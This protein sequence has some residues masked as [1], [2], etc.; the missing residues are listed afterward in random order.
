MRQTIFILLLLACLALAFAGRIKSESEE[1]EDWEGDATIDDPNDLTIKHHDDGNWSFGYRT[2]NN[3]EVHEESENTDIVKG[4]Y[5]YVDPDG[6][7]VK[8]T[9]I[10]GAGIGFVPYS[11]VIDD[12]IMKS[13]E[14]NLK[15]PPQNFDSSEEGA[16]R[17]PVRDFSFPT[18]SPK[19]R[20]VSNVVENLDKGFETEQKVKATTVRN[21][22]RMRKVQSNLAEAVNDSEKEIVENV[23]TPQAVDNNENVKVNVKTVE[24]EKLK[25]KLIEESKTVDDEVKVA[26]DDLK[27]EES[28]SDS[29]AKNLD[30]V[31]KVKDAV[32]K[33]VNRGRKTASKVLAEAKQSTEKVSEDEK[34]VDKL[35]AEDVSDEVKKLDEVIDE[36]LKAVKLVKE[37]VIEDSQRFGG[38]RRKIDDQVRAIEDNENVDETTTVEEPTTVKIQEIVTQKSSGRKFNRVR[39]IQSAP[40]VDSD[41]DLDITQNVQNAIENRLNTANNLGKAVAGNVRNVNRRQ[42]VRPTV[43]TTTQR[44]VTTTTEVPITTTIQQTETT[45]DDA[46]VTE[47]VTAVVDAIME[48]IKTAGDL[49]NVVVKNVKKLKKVPQIITDEIPEASVG[50]KLEKSVKCDEVKHKVKVVDPCEK[51]DDAVTATEETT[52]MENTTT[53]PEVDTTESIEIATTT[54]VST[55]STSPLY[56]R[57]RGKFRNRNL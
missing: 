36:N 1:D 22:N 4:E 41:T 53:L 17:K 13:I 45:I 38:I 12:A 50:E 49:K 40:A 37:T 31:K 7:L 42:R 28:L 24:N 11:N 43:T 47:Q 15:N 44:P 10:A 54:E 6:R 33:N 55:S 16:E 30:T 32:V 23:E 35:V 3:I 57:S 27:T 5:S 26:V 48:N 8:V 18:F 9:Y 2:S 56:F 46:P 51:E 14:L 21:M 20:K 34:V 52:T 39:K 19:P 29:I 25:P